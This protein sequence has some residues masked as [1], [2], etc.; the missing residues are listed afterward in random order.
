[1]AIY[2]RWYPHDLSEPAISA[3]PII[4][5]KM[6]VYALGRYVYAF[7]AGAGNPGWDV[8]EL[9]KGSQPML[10]VD[11][12]GLRIGHGSHIYLFENW[13]HKWTDIDTNAILDAPPFNAT[14]GAK[15]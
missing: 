14:E 5:D 13:S 2:G 15:K 4:G 8:L 1:V 9:P 3:T 12:D 10:S 7:G 11:S 6:A